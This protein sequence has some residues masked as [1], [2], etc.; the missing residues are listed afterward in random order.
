MLSLPSIASSGKRVSS[1]VVPSRLATDVYV[2]RHFASRRLKT[3]LHS[4]SLTMSTSKRNPVVGRLDTASGGKDHELQF[5][6]EANQ[7]GC[8]FVIRSQH[9]P[10]GILG[11]R[12]TLDSGPTSP[13]YDEVYAAGCA[14][15]EKAKT[16]VTSPKS[17]L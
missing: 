2:S 4:E 6:I 14:A 15:F 3:P 16:P 11:R 17:P 1:M 5:Y 7:G 10:G 8:A 9:R 12:C 13:D